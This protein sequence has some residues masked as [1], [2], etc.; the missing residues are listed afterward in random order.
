MEDWFPMADCHAVWSYCGFSFRGRDQS[1]LEGSSGDRSRVGLR[2][3]FAV[4]GTGMWS[5]L[6]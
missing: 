6:L 1:L 2:H 5:H 4:N 3:S